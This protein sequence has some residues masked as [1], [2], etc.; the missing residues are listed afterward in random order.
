MDYPL[1]DLSADSKACIDNAENLSCNQAKLG[2]V[3]K[4]TF[5]EYG[6]HHQATSRERKV[7][8]FVTI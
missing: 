7:L 6:L 3:I 8:L 4:R 5:T 1:V 2:R